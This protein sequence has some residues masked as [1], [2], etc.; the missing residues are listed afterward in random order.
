MESHKQ[1]VEAVSTLLCFVNGGGAYFHSGS[2]CGGPSSSS[3][4]SAHHWLHFPSFV[5][6]RRNCGRSFQKESERAQECCRFF[7]LALFW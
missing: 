6:P 1:K 2:I 3:I 5:I 4:I 7:R